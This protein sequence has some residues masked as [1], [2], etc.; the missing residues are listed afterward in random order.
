MGMLRVLVFTA[1][2]LFMP[3]QV[4]AQNSTEEVT[5][6]AYESLGQSIISSL[7]MSEDERF[8]D[9]DG[10]IILLGEIDSDEARNLLIEFLGLYIGESHGEAL[11]Y[12]IERQ[13]K[14]IQKALEININ[15][16]K[17]CVIKS[18][19]KTNLAC[20]EEGSVKEKSKDLLLSISQG[21]LPEYPL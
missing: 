15:P 17:G 19:F 7:E 13:G 1:F 2:L 10:L 3:H 18:K 5:S 20:L 8:A 21:G 14:K 6:F 9:A 16:Y 12:A 4:F 11:S